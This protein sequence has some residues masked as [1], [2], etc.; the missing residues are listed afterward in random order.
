[1]TEQSLIIVPEKNR[2]AAES[3][4]DTLRQ[5]RRQNISVDDL[6]DMTARAMLALHQNWQLVWYADMMNKGRFKPKEITW[7]D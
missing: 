7:P 4:R 5:M 2:Q 3:Y 6:D 1:M